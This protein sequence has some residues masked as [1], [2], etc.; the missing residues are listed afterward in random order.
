MT[1]NGINVDFALLREELP[2]DAN[3]DIFP[4]RGIRRS[5]EVASSQIGENTIFRWDVLLGLTFLDCRDH[6]SQYISLC[7]SDPSGAPAA[8]ERQL[9]CTPKLNKDGE[10]G[11][12]LMA[13]RIAFRVGVPGRYTLRVQSGLLPLHETYFWI[14]FR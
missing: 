7:I 10:S 13:V 2:G 5:F 12:C 1:E 3:E 14:Y 9:A 11:Y 4:I 6:R 8:D